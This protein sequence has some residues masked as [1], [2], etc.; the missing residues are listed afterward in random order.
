MKTSHPEGLLLASECFPPA[1]G[2][3]AELLFNIYSRLP[4]PV[5]VLTASSSDGGSFAS[6]S[7]DIVRTRFDARLGVASPASGAAH[8]RLA[9]QMRRLTGR[10]DVIHC[11]R[12]LP[13]GTIAMLASIGGGRRYV[14]WTHG[15]ELPIAATSRELTWLMKRVHRGAAA[16]LANSHNTARLLR[17]WG[18]PAGKIQVVHP[19]VD[20]TRF[21]AAGNGHG[22][23]RRRLTNGDDEIVLLSVGRLQT[24]KGHDLVLKAM[25]ALGPA[26]ARLR[27]VVAGDGDEAGRLQRFAAELGVASRVTFLGTVPGDELPAYYAAADVF[28]LPNRI[29]RGDFEGFGIVFLEA[30][31]AGLPVIGGRSGGVPEAIDEGK[32]GLLVSGADAEELAQ[33]IRSLADD[34]NLRRTLGEAGRARVLREFTWARAAERVNQIDLEVRSRP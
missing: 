30:A 3:S 11:G 34:A 28:V 17:D 31:A 26:G 32:T 29:E 20:A 33:A 14:C 21:T 16:L 23:L 10:G 7:L 18:N 13:E 1:V 6:G 12:A 2:G 25:A 8:V 15:E 4:R 9:R 22:D 27:Y 5:T 19:G 24:R